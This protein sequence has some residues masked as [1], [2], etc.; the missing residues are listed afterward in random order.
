MFAWHLK[1]FKMSHRA[2]DLFKINKK[3]SQNNRIDG[4][5]FC[6]NLNKYRKTAYY[7]K[8]DLYLFIFTHNLNVFIKSLVLLIF[9]FKFPVAFLNMT[10]HDK[11]NK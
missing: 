2:I 3:Q 7:Y 11:L 8:Y 4:W 6:K 1:I 5:Y 10:P 9:F